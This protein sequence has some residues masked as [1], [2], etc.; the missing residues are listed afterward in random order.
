MI[1]EWRNHFPDEPV[2]VQLQ[3]VYP[4]NG[5]GESVVLYD[6]VVDER[7]ESGRPGTV[8]LAF[9][10][11]PVIRWRF[12][13]DGP[14]LLR[15]TGAVELGL[16]RRGSEWLASAHRANLSGGFINQAEFLAPNA[17]LH[18]VVAHWINL[19]NIRA[20]GRIATDIACWNGRWQCEVEGWRITVDRRND[21]DVVMQS[22]GAE[23][24]FVLTHVMEV[25]RTDDAPFDAECAKQLLDGLRVCMSFAFGRWVAPALPVGYDD[26]G[27]VV[28]EEW[29]APICDPAEVV[30]LGWLYPLRSDELAHLLTRALPVLVDKA[31]PGIARYQMVSAVL[32]TQSGFVEQRVLAA[33]SAL[34]NIEWATLVLGGI[35]SRRDYRNTKLWPGHRRLRHLLKLAG[36]PTDIDSV[37]LPA[38]ASFATAEGLP[39]GPAAL[40]GVRNRLA[41][42]KSPNDQVYHLDGL[43]GDASFLAR[44]YLT[45]LILHS[46]DYQGSYVRLTQIGRAHV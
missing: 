11:R 15:G 34:E 23:S 7:Q 2:E 17:R 14:R 30:G 39:D 9:A 37:G 43:V 24:S 13:P 8:E 42:P 46:I 36:I 5:V 44:H 4:F 35:V 26:A 10:G 28:W 1:E 20:S 16:R 19:P 40:S 21:Y 31:G 6:G 18:R 32:C 27:Q 33:F 29:T 25:R 22:A 41:H 3:P 12:D 38:L 45:L